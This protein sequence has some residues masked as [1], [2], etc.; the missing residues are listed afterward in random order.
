MH[1]VIETPTFLGD[2]RRARLPDDDRLAMIDAIAE[3]PLEGEIIP[4]TGGARKRRFAGRG[5]GK[6][7]GYRVISFYAGD[8]VPVL[9]LALIDKGERANISKAGAQHVAPS[10]GDLRCGVSCG[11][12]EETMT[13][14]GRRLIK[15]AKEGVA[16]AR[17]EQDPATYRVHIPDDIDVKTIR[18]NFELTQS[19]FAAR[20]AIPE[21]T[22]R[23]WEQHRRKPS[24]MARLFL[25]LL[26]REPAAV[27]RVLAS[28]VRWRS[29]GRRGERRQR[30]AAL[31]GGRGAPARKPHGARPH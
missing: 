10:A 30:P 25:L 18:E 24:G 15:A 27:R 12:E 14:L 3:D 23:D 31:A 11:A 8:D 13:D 29:G 4:G 6:S 5:R 22:L 7:G 17:N 2:C 28:L 19:G 9:M 21:A 16:I 26:A 20:F 1:T